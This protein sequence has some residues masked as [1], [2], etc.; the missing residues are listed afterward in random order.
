MSEKPTTYLGLLAKPIDLQELASRPEFADANAASKAEITDRL[1]LLFKHYDVDLTLTSEQAWSSL[2]IKL[3]FAHVP[4]FQFATRAKR[5]AKRKWTLDECQSLV[6]A[7]N[8]QN[9]AKGL[10]GAIG[11]AIKQ[12]DWKWGAN[13]GSIEVR[14]HEAMR[15]IK[16]QEFVRDHPYTWAALEFLMKTYSPRKNRTTKI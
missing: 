3:A 7:V 15:Q 11:R 1:G 6:S 13:I 10:K 16:A 14:Y 12:K 8:A 4:G 2:A 9:T 5:G